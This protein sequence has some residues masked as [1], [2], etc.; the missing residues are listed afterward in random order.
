MKMKCFIVV[1]LFNVITISAQ[2]RI[3]IF[4]DFDKHEINTTAMQKLTDWMEYSQNI[5]V[6]KIYGFCDWKGTNPYNDTLSVKR[7]QAVYRFLKAR[8]IKIKDDYEI[9]GFGEDFTQSK[10]QSENRKVSIVFENIKESEPKTPEAIQLE[11]L[12]KK[13]KT[14]KSGDFI[15]LKNIYFYNFSAK[16]VPKSKPILYEL[17]CTME[18][19]PKLKIEIQGHI[20]CQTIAG[21]HDVSSA[22][23][24]TIYNFLIINKIDRKRLSFKGFGVTKPIHPIPEKS[25]QEEDENRRVEILIL[26][27]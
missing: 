23:A 8:N 15:R 2:K 7:V 12:S 26:D 22:R 3:E 6:Q 10:V 17:L 13:I 20:C 9:K 19:N 1:F 16:L 18:E 14:A 5:E 4:F 11:E 21:L 24:K 27:N 25:E